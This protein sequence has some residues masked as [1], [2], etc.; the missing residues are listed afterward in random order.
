MKLLGT[1]FRANS[2]TDHL[3]SDIQNDVR[4]MIGAL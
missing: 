3:L 2:A 4:Q 1:K